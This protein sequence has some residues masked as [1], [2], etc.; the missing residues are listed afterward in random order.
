VGER[1][2]RTWVAYL[3][4]ASVGFTEGA[5]GLYQIVAA[6]P[7]PAVSVAVPSTREAIYAPDVEAV[8]RRAS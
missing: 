6:R 1:T 7:D 5:L 8:A 4:G 3:A 2:Y